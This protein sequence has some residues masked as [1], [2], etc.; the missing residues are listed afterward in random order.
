MPIPT[1][2]RVH[3]LAALALEL[4]ASPASD[5][6]PRALAQRDAGA[7]ADLVARDLAGFH[8]DAARL[9]LVT[10]GAH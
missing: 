5:A 1:D 7:L 9:D 10:V 3:V 4:S 2:D 6:R 8:P